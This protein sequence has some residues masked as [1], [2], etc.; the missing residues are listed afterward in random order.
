[1]EES[2]PAL[3][4][5]GSDYWPNWTNTTNPLAHHFLERPKQLTF[6]LSLS[7]SLSSLQNKVGHYYRL[8]AKVRV[9]LHQYNTD[10][11][12]KALPLSLVKAP[13]T[14][15][16]AP[17]CVSMAKALPSWHEARSSV[18]YH[19]PRLC[20]RTHTVHPHT[21]A[22]VPQGKRGLVR[23]SRSEGTGIHRCPYGVAIMLILLL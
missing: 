12:K 9:I 1:M 18:A 6:P 8:L 2:V 5:F 15:S 7:R 11:Y 19:S 21:G 20:P 23:T 16:H 3:K 17:M 4:S 14:Q 22:V 13:Q 10:N